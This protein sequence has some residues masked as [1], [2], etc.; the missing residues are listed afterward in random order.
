MLGSGVS[1]RETTSLA[2][3][4]GV[5]RAALSLAVELRRFF[6]LL[7]RDRHRERVRTDRISVG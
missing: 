5:A 2:A 6:F 7:D 1:A 4:T 3:A